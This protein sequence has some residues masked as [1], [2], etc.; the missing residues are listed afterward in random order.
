[1][2]SIGTLAIAQRRQDE[3]KALELQRRFAQQYPHLFDAHDLTL[4]LGAQGRKGYHFVE[5][6]GAIVLHLA[7][8]YNALVSKYQYSKHSA[9]RQ[10]I[11]S[12]GLSDLVR[13]RH[14]VYGNAQGPDLLMY[15]AD[16]TDYFF[17]EI[18][19]PDDALRNAQPA[20]FEH[21]ERETGRPVQLLRFKWARG[22][23]GA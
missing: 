1:M 19:G 9:K 8:G 4:A 17:C 18:K 20:Y 10:V 11:R 22:R 23:A 13:Q 16:L 2:K 14:P 5:W 7:T 15:R 12:L 21:L 3:W 6:L